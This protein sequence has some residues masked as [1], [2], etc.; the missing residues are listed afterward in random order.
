M[1]EAANQSSQSSHM[2]RRFHS[3]LFKF[4][5]ATAHELVH[6]FTSYLAQGDTGENSLTP[7]Q[8]SH[9]DYGRRVSFGD[10][11]E[12]SQLAA[13]QIPLGESGRWFEN[14]L[15][16]GSLE[17]YEDSNDDGDQVP[18]LFTPHFHKITDR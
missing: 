3:Y 10:G 2:R 13:T 18:T 17:F 11:E 5:V 15:F 7:P 14:S 8:L 4:G 1:T 12:G 9:L 6:C 16:G